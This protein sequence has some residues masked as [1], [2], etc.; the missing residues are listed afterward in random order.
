MR[1]LPLLILSV[2]VLL[3]VGLFSYT[4]RNT[5]SI[6]DTYGNWNCYL[7]DDTSTGLSF[8]LKP[9]KIAKYSFSDESGTQSR[10]N[11]KYD[12]DE[13][14]NIVYLIFD[15]PIKSTKG[16]SLMSKDYIEYD[17]ISHCVKVNV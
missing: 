17:D 12:F 8:S 10:S 1:N 4:F 16:I 11:G 13:K 14:H 5:L 6:T 9:G 2:I 3:A 15:R 7:N